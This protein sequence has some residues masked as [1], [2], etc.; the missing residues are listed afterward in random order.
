MLFSTHVYEVR[1]I[2]RR[3]RLLKAMQHATGGAHSFPKVFQGPQR[4]L[5][6]VRSTHKFNRHHL[7]FNLPSC[8][9][10]RS[11]RL[12]HNMT[13][14]SAISVAS[15]V[16]RVVDVDLGERSYPIYI[17]RGVLEQGELLRKHVPGKKVL[18]VTN[19]TIAPLYLSR[20]L[21]M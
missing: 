15:E 9:W 2:I 8:H 16:I 17:G 1:K 13:R 6:C 11:S 5:V 4:S 14:N 12:C 3:L 7:P 20:W 10:P 18:V 19:E 21:P